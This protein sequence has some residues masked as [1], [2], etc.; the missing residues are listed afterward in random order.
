MARRSIPAGLKWA[1]LADIGSLGGKPTRA[2]AIKIGQRHGLGARTIERWAAV[3]RMAA[4]PPLDTAAGGPGA[5][6][7]VPASIGLSGVEVA[8]EAMPQLTGAPLAQPTT[9][10]GTT[11]APAAGAVVGNP[12]LAMKPL[13]TLLCDLFNS[14]A[15]AIADEGA[16]E[17]GPPP[18]PP[19][20]EEEKQ[21]L[22]EALEAAAVKFAPL[23]AEHMVEINLVIVLAAVFGPRLLAVKA[24]RE[25][26]N[27]H[28]DIY[29]PA[30]AASKATSPPARA[31]LPAPAGSRTARVTRAGAAVP[32]G[33]SEEDAEAAAALMK[34]LGAR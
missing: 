25:W 32:R 28:R 19:I 2:Q 23:L 8:A 17:E 30:P 26:H 7:P 15:L 14:R 3:S 18:I 13:A 31:P 21:A 10:P 4:E 22:A 9:Q 29:I 24:R 34:K 6:S 20:T 12:T 27:E 33:L 5:P 16:A 1:V 11:P